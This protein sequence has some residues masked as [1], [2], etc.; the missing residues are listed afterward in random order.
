M[1]SP[2]R[3]LDNLK[4]LFRGRIPGQLIIQYS[5]QCNADCPQC[6]MRRSGKVPRSTLDKDRVR[7]LI[8]TAAQNGVKSLSFTGG[9]PL[10]FLDDILELTRHADKA[11]IPYVRTGTNGFIFQD[12]KSSGFKGKITRIAEKIASTNLYTFWISIDSAEP[13]THEKMRGLKG[14]IKGIE[15]ALPIFHQHGIYPSVNLGINRATGGTTSLPF[16]QRTS[17]N[18][19]LDSFQTSFE[20]FYQ[21]VLDL[22]FTIVNACYPMSSAID[23]NEADKA[24]GSLNRSL[25]GA[26]SDDSIITF[27]KQE[28]ALIFQALLQ[29]VPKYRGKLRIFSPRCSLYDLMR[30]FTD[31]QDSLFPCRGGSDFFFVEC[32]N[33][34]IHPCGYREAPNSKFPDL[35][36]RIRRDIDCNRCEWECFRDPSDVLG[37]FADFFS[38]PFQLLGKI[39]K[40]PQ[41]FRLLR[42]D[43]S[44]YRACGFFNGRLAPQFNKMRHF[45]SK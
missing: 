31:R 34:L 41:F 10:M 20:R 45:Q 40:D 27:S 21:F 3:N 1:Q 17:A 18:A 7:E 42:E 15:S 2:F 12:S 43:L 4:P 29:T 22:G 6:G 36:Q 11:G 5:N 39:V 25:Y 19:F 16:L 33:G 44:Y 37:P 13:D 23:Y 26:A 30:K 8:D 24:P 32:E 28:K 35:R 9:E 38:Q 14:V